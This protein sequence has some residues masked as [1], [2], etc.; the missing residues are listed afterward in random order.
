MKK[1]YE[2]TGMSCDECVNSVKQALM[3]LPDVTD[4]EVKLNPQGVLLTMSESIDTSVLQ[5]QVDK[6]GQYTILNS[7]G[8]GNGVDEDTPIIERKTS[9]SNTHPERNDRPFGIDHEPGVQ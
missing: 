6:A 9:F 4:A 5:G 2:L 8:D 1:Y 7:I 3:E